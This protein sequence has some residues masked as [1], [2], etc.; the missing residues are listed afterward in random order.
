MPTEGGY[1]QSAWLETDVGPLHHYGRRGRVDNNIVELFIYNAS[2]M[3]YSAGSG[4]KRVHVVLSGLR[5][6]VSMFVFPVGMT[7]CLILLCLCH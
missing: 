1:H 6:F 7:E 5:L 2:C 3:L 4:V